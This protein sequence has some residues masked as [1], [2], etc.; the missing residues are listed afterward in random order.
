MERYWFDKF[1][2]KICNSF[3]RL[4]F[5]YRDTSYCNLIM[6]VFVKRLS[7]ATKKTGSVMPREKQYQVLELNLW[8]H[9]VITG[10]RRFYKI[11]HVGFPKYFY[12][13]FI[14]SIIHMKLQLYSLVCSWE[15]LLNELLLDRILNSPELNI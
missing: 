3:I 12:E 2:L 15:F 13:V 10:H 14:D 8:N 4:N 7:S 9:G 1:L 5:D 6:K 11:K